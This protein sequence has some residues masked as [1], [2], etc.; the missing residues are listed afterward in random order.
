MSHTFNT[1]LPRHLKMRVQKNMTRSILQSY[2]HTGKQN[3]SHLLL[4]FFYLSL[5]RVCLL[6]FFCEPVLTRKRIK[7]ETGHYREA[8]KVS[9][10]QR[11]SKRQRQLPFVDCTFFCP[12]ARAVQDFHA[13]SAICNTAF[14]IVLHI[15]FLVSAWPLGRDDL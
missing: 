11:F 13:A 12:W 6:L 4:L 1:I 7:N 8:P 3:V 5:R 10:G 9:L 2:T 15:Y 14:Y